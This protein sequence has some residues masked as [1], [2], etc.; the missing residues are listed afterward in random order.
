M[1][2]TVCTKRGAKEMFGQVG[3]SQVGGG[4]VKLNNEMESWGMILPAEEKQ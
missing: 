2:Q 1:E 4:R 3:R